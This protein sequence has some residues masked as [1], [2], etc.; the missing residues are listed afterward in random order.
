MVS[1]PGH[2]RIASPYDT[3]ARRGVKREELWLGCKLHITETCDDAPACAC[4]PATAQPGAAAGGREHDKGCA[5]L[6]F[7]N[8]ITQV[9]TAGAT[10][11]DNQMANSIHDGLAGK[12][13]APG[14]HYLDSGYLSATLVVSEMARH[15]I[16]LIGPLLADTSAQARAGAGYARLHRRLR[17]PDRHLPAGQGISVPDAVQPARQG[18]DRGHL[19]RQRPR[20]VPG[21]RLVH[22]RQATAAVAAAP[23]PGRSSGRRPGRGNDAPVPGRLRP[24]GRSRGCHAPGHQPRCAARPL[25]RPAQDPPR[26]RVH[27]RRPQPAPA[28]GLLDRTPLDRRRTSHL[29]R[30][31]LGLVA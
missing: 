26:P 29:A 1:R 19:L 3:D 17:H 30:L 25:P 10:V 20:P 14:R 16:A 5:H 9:A 2:A 24:P 15:G 22:D 8:L 4:Q 13:L 31:E 18:R 21:P 27:G 11:T 28:G 12:K 23:R 7:P 6:V